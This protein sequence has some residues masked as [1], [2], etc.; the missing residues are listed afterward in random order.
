VSAQHFRGVVDAVK[1]RI[2]GLALDLEKLNPEAG[3]PGSLATGAAAVTTVVYNHIYGDGN[4]IAVAGH[5]D[6]T[7]IER[8]RERDLD[9]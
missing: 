8:V 6:V 4:N 9:S 3:E 5:D 7:H 1:T 2:L